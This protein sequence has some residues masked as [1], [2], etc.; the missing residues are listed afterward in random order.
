VKCKCIAETLNPERLP[1]KRKGL[2]VFGKSWCYGNDST[3]S[4]LANIPCNLFEGDCLSA[5]V[6]NKQP[7]RTPQEKQRPKFTTIARPLAPRAFC[8]GWL[9]DVLG[10][11]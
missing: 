1:T 8:P 9:W 2:K 3:E 5:H 7:K 11:F 6:F 4:A 10:N